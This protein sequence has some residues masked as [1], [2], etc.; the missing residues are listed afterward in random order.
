MPWP[1]EP[2]S[3]GLVLGQ[4]PDDPLCRGCEQP[5]GDE[6]ELCAHCGEIAHDGCLILTSNAEKVCKPCADGEGEAPGEDD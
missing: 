4:D 2:I 3:R 1:I 5:V 6:G